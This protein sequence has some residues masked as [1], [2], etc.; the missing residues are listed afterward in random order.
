MA[1][2]LL[3]ALLLGALGCASP[4]ATAPTPCGEDDDA[5]A[6]TWSSPVRLTFGEDGLT[7]PVAPGGAW[8]S[9]TLDDSTRC[10]QVESV[11]AAG[12]PLV[13]AGSRGIFCTDCIYRVMG[14][15]GGG[16]WSFDPGT[17]PLNGA[18]T[19]RVG[20]RDCATWVPIR[21]EGPLGASLRVTTPA[22]DDPARAA[23]LRV[24]VAAFGELW[25][26]DAAAADALLTA[27]SAELAGAGISLQR[28]G[29]CALPAPAERLE[30][31]DN[32][33]AEVARWTA[34]A[35]ARCPALGTDPARPRLT[36]LVAPCVR[37]RDSVRGESRAVDGYTTHIPG[38]A[39]LD[40]TPDAVLLSA[41]CGATLPVFDGVP[42]GLGRVL[43]HEVGHF[44]GLFHTSEAE[45]V[46]DLD[47]FDDTTER[48]LMNAVPLRPE[49]RGLSRSQ[50][51]V[52][53]RHPWL[54]RS[55]RGACARRDG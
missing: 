4:P 54:R 50:I 38:G 29:F 3:S 53:R 44:L 46:R 16:L 31:T 40:D 20:L 2:A 10:A 32:G 12:R 23:V 48:N 27:A 15:V 35:R 51:D 5:P 28:S 6:P 1:R 45:G 13:P 17:H 30:I 41:G 9:L 43:G 14:L 33:H 7:A 11:V 18:V 42:L 47:P 34:L 8:L 39:L 52:A 19:L 55:L 26:R 49:A 24:N 36:L 37:T 25:L 21:G 22:P